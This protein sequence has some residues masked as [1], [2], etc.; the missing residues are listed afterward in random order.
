M[1][2]ERGHFEKGAWIE[3]REENPKERGEDD[4]P[5]GDPM[6]RRIREVS[7]HLSVSLSELVS[8]ACDIVATPEGHAHIRGFLEKTSQEIERTLSGIL[9][10][11]EK[12]DGERGPAE[13]KDTG[14]R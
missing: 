8:L 3:E 9:S 4:I 5:G 13:E 2:Q 6:E 10:S 7:T 14:K 1:N 12:E 11:E